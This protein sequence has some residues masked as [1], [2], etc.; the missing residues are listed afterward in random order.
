MSWLSACR[1]PP[2]AA[3]VSSPFSTLYEFKAPYDRLVKAV[4]SGL[5]IGLLVLMMGISYLALSEGGDAGLLALIIV[6]V[7]VIPILI[8]PYL[9]SPRA[10]GITVKG[11]LVK[12]PLKSFL[13]PYDDIVSVKKTSWTWRGIR[14]FASGGFY[15]FFGLFRISGLGR[16]WMYVTDRNRMLL[17][18][19]KQGVKYIISPSD[20]D[21]FMERLKSIKVG[22]K[23]A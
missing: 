18:E 7:V 4:T 8:I 6:V 16:V 2:S 19:T 15:G 10:F 14:L 12:R 21:L 5:I 20:P 9:Y 11:I 13:I 22:V 17:I 1:L 3:P 23:E